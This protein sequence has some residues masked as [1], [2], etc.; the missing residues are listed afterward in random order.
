MKTISIPTYN[1]PF[2][3]KINNN[4]YT[5]KGGETIEVPDEVAEAIENALALE[6]K[7]KVYL[8]RFAKFIE[9]S[10]TEITKSDLDGVVN[11][12]QCAFY[13]SIN[14]KRAVIPDTVFSIGYAA[15][16]TCNGLESVIIGNGI[17]NIGDFAFR[18]CN[19][20]KRVTMRPT[21][22]PTI[23]EN[24]FLNI[25]IACV[26][27]VPAMSVEEYKSAPYWNTLANQIVAIEE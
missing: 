3:V 22:P 2:I 10:I 25:P 26:I 9:G 8:D 11:I 18:D 17:T 13:N 19:G 20:L 5:Y 16:G 23:K 14:I 24:T 27:E 21:H 12:S 1:N 4:E 15:F 7:P 6:P